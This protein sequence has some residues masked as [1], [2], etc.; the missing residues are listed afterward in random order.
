[1]RG[2]R[3]GMM[4]VTLVL[5]LA[6]NFINSS[7]STA[8]AQEPVS[9][10]TPT[11]SSATG[12][13]ITV[14]TT[15]EDHANVRLGPGSA[16]YPIIGILPVGATAPALG[17]SP[18]GDWVQ[19]EFPNAQGGN[20]GW[21][22]V[23]LVTVSPGSLPIVEPPPT[24]VPPASPTLDPTLA[25]QFQIEPTATR[26]PTFTPAPSLATPGFEDKPVNTRGMP[27]PAGWII[28]VLGTVGTTGLLISSLQRSAVE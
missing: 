1:M 8:Y 25:A 23:A 10:Q 3:I 12:I 28:L 14:T 16:I 7:R 24:P 27:I 22:Y 17:R 2:L 6:W 15:T 5:T 19:I 11:Q 20:K 13:Y 9:T 18:G 4:V 21:V 26:L